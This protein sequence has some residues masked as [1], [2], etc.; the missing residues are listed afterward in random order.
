MIRGNKRQ[1]RPRCGAATSIDTMI[2]ALRAATCRANSGSESG[3]ARCRPPT[4]LDS[5]QAY[6]PAPGCPGGAP[7]RLRAFEGGV[8]ALT[9]RLA[10]GVAE[11]KKPSVACR[12]W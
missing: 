11:P 1:W 12:S 5:R 10:D 4:R 2:C 7:C 6:R 9:G 8:L 3:L